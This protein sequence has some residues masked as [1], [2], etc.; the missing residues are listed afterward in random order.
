LSSALVL[1][2]YDPNLKLYLVGDASAYGV[3]VEL[4]QAYS[5]GSECPIA[6][7]LWILNSSECNYAQV[8]K[9]ALSLIFDFIS[10]SMPGNLH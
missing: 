8:E 2:H 1:A 5:D 4:S 7:A 10:I 9:E 6:Y 3:G